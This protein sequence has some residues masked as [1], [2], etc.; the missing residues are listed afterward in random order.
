MGIV[1][2]WPAGWVVLC[3]LTGALYAWWLYY[4]DLRRGIS[5]RRVVRFMLIF[6]FLSV[7]LISFLILSPLIRLSEKVIEKP[8]VI[9]GIANSESVINSP[10]S[11]FYRTTWPE[12]L[13]ELQRGLEEKAEVRIFSIGSGV[14]EGFNADFTDKESDLSSFFSEIKTRFTNR[15]VAAV[16]LASDGI[17]TQGI[18]PFYAA[19]PVAWPVYTVALGDTTIR[20]DAIVKK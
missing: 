11:L 15:N 1:T 7:T 9:L 20:K 10:D 8:V 2:E 6:R 14:R 13:R 3:L 4:H 19:R 5:A 16:V 12:Q 17:Y 18:D